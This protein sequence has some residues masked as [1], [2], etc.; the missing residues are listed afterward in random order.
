[1]RVGVSEGVSS[2]SG[3]EGHHRNPSLCPPPWPEQCWKAEQHCTCSE[4]PLAGKFR[5][6]CFGLHE[7]GILWLLQPDLFQVL[8]PQPFILKQ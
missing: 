5:W 1:M 2:G 7:H 8:K 4:L 6:A 3:L